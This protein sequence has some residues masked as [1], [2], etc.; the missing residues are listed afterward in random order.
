[1]TFYIW[2]NPKFF[3]LCDLDWP[4][5]CFNWK[6][7]VKSCQEFHFDVEFGYFQ[8]SSKFDFLFTVVLTLG[9]LVLPWKYFVSKGYVKSF[10]LTWN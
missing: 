7:D 4:F 5:Y 1:M 2:I 8:S 6:A 9:D 10:I 3:T